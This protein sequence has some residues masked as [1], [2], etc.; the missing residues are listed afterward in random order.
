[1][2]DKTFVNEL[3]FVYI[4]K[5]TYLKPIFLSPNDKYK[6]NYNKVLESHRNML[7]AKNC[8]N[9]LTLSDLNCEI[10]CTSFLFIYIH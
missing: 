10:E 4:W 9:L 2:F 3:F 8:F 5:W 6:T 1:M 7:E